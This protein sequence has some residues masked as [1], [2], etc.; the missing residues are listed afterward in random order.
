MWFGRPCPPRESEASHLGVLPAAHQLFHG[1]GENILKKKRGG[2]LVALE[3]AEEV[4]RAFQL[5]YALA[6][7]PVQTLLLGQDPFAAEDV[8]QE[9]IATTQA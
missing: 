2:T 1:V 5:A 6:Q 8:A 9:G 7:G 3:N 4:L